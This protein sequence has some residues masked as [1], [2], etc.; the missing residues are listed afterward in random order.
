MLYDVV[1]A[2]GGPAGLSAALILGRARKRVLLCDAGPRRNAAAEH[3]HGFVTQDGTPPTEFRRIARAQLAPYESVEVRDVGVEAISGERGDFTVRLADGSVHARRVL[4]CLGMV[5]EVPDL[6]G[7]RALWGRAIFQCPYCHGWEAR[8]RTFAVLLAGE[9]Y[10]DF[11]LLLRGWTRDV[12][13]LTDGRFA[14]PPEARARLAAAGVRLD[15]RPLERV[16][17]DGDRLV[18]VEL[19]AGAR[20]ACDVLVMRP[21]QRQTALVAGLG[22]DLDEQGFVRITPQMATSRPGILAAGDLTTPMQGALLAAAAGA[23]AAYGMNHELTVELAL[24]GALP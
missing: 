7:V 5:D 9:A 18:A 16:I 12:I 15:E 19:A 13:A 10:L 6:P 21:P 4:L 3:I 2:G 14:V 24:A 22:L 17:A 8:D 1:I 11:P 20:V 23:Q